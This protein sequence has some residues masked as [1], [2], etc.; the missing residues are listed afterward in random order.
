M[1]LLPEYIC[2]FHPVQLLDPMSG[3]IMPSSPYYKME[4]TN[5]CVYAIQVDILV[6]ILLYPVRI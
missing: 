2:D 5:N 4:C 1:L 3:K 6:N